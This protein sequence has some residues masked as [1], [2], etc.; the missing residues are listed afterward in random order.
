MKTIC[1]TAVDPHWLKD[2]GAY[3][4]KNNT[5]RYGTCTRKKTAVNPYLYD[6]GAQP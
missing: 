2:D 6:Y 1:T 4:G 3:R 5:H